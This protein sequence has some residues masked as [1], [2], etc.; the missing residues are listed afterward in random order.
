M[1]ASVT[2]SPPIVTVGDLLER[3]GGVSSERV[4]FDPIPGTAT[5]V[6]IIALDRREDRLYELI[7]G[8]VVEKAYGFRES[9]IGSAIAA[10]LLTFARPRKLGLVSGAGGPFQFAPTLVRLPDVAF[11]SWD[12]VPS[13]RVPVEPVPAMVPDLAVDVRK[14]DNTEAELAR[15][16][17]DYF[18]AGVRL[19]WLVDPNARTVAVYDAPDRPPRILGEADT[20]DG[21]SVL[22]GLTLSLKGLFA[23]LDR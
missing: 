23:E 14:L 8:V 9:V 21:G 5:V 15:K 17:R 2:F 1:T 20:L 7:D 13:R 18:Y 19:V 12:R 4:R 11:I 10:A 3:L 22:A 16:R 6:D